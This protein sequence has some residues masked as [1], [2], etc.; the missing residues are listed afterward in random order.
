MWSKNGFFF[1]I[2]VHP[3]TV[4]QSPAYDFSVRRA[5][6]FLTPFR[7]VLSA[8]HVQVTDRPSLD[9]PSVTQAIIAQMVYFRPVDYPFSNFWLETGSNS[10][11]LI[12]VPLRASKQTPTFSKY[13]LSLSLS[14]NL[15]LTV[16]H[17]VFAGPLLS[18]FI[19]MASTGSH[20]ANKKSTREKVLSSIKAGPLD[21]SFWSFLTFLHHGIEKGGRYLLWKF[22]KKLKGKVGQ[23]CHRSCSLA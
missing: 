9:A 1:S 7:T 3:V 4:G 17:V 12:F 16:N 13:S 8:I 5:A 15:S 10:H 22:H 20:N 23:M 18:L 19:L 2:L 6:V 11:D 21:L 14:F